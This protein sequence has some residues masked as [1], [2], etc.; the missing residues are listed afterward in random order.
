MANQISFS[1]APLQGRQRYTS[2]QIDEYLQAQPR[3]GLS[4]AAFCQKHGLYPSLFYNWKRR[5][6]ESAMV[7]PAFRE[8]S[9]P[10]LM[11]ASW[12]AEIALPS[13]AMLR[14]SAQADWSSLRPWLA[15]LLRP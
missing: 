11:D 5:R 4:V 10:V 14:L 2:D 6:K 13:G 3:S 12:V 15:E 9:L 8:V 7:A 1:T